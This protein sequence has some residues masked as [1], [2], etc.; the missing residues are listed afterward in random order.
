M[1]GFFGSFSS[2]GKIDNTI[3]NQVSLIHRG[4]D[5]HKI[6]SDQY[7]SGDFFRLDII[8]GEAANQ[9]MISYNKNLVMFFN[10]E[11]YNYLELK[12]NISEYKFQTSSDTEVL[13]QLLERKKRQAFYDLEGMWSLAWFQKK[14][15]KLCKRN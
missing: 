1:C 12:D 7:F 8:G 14:E 3:R 9:P 6:F 4:P 13:I 11:I 15:S 5:S 10:G 2:E